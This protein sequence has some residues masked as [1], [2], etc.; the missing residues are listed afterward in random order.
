MDLQSYFV[1]F[2]EQFICFLH[3][4]VLMA[5]LNFTLSIT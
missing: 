4:L 5:F 3:K 1:N 2:E